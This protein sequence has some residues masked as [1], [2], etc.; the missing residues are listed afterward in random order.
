LRVGLPP[1]PAKSLKGLCRMTYLC[2]V[3][4]SQMAK[5]ELPVTVWK[6]PIASDTRSQDSAERGKRAP[7]W[8]LRV[9][10]K[11]AIRPLQPLSRQSL[12]GKLCEVQRLLGPAQ[13]RNTSD[14]VLVFWRAIQE[15]S[16]ASGETLEL[17][18][19]AQDLRLVEAE[20]AGKSTDGVIMPRMAWRMLVLAALVFA[21]Q[22]RG[23]SS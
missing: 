23:G 2:G 13:C 10:K 5:V 18:V 3:S 11:R 12:A 1:R 8:A 21:N 9:T 14:M 17:P 6:L 22:R 4:H 16:S 7:F 15:A 20:Q 19:L